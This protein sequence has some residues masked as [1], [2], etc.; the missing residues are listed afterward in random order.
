M[1]N[2]VFHVHVSCL[3]QWSN[4]DE[5]ITSG[6]ETNK[7]NSHQSSDWEDSAPKSFKIYSSGPHRS[8]VSDS[9]SCMYCKSLQTEQ[10]LSAILSLLEGRL[11]VGN[12][13]FWKQNVI[14]LRPPCLCQVES[15]RVAVEEKKQCLGLRIH[16]RRNHITKSQAYRAAPHLNL[17]LSLFQTHIQ[18]THTY[19]H[20]HTHT[21]TRTPRLTRFS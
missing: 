14:H 11:R 6:V 7:S 13:Q 12:H 9:F 2:C 8:H 21:H 19:T 5:T 17:S 18:Y 4:R 15:A 1:W 3:R 16:F 20:T 10:R